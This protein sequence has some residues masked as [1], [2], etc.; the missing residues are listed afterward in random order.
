MLTADGVV[1]ILDFGLA[2]L[3]GAAGLT[4]AG[5]CLGTPAYMSPE[6]ARGEVDP[7][8]DL[9]SLGVV[10][11]EMLTGAPPFPGDI[12]P[13]GDLRAA[14]RRA[15][16]GRRKLRP[17]VPPE[18]ERI[19]HGML[20]KDPATA[21]DRRRAPWPTCAPSRLDRRFHGAIAAGAVRASRSG[22]PGCSPPPACVARRRGGRHAW[23]LPAVREP[24][25]QLSF[26]RLTDLEGREMFPS[27]SPAGDV[28][29]YAKVQAASDLDIFWQ[30]VGGGNPRI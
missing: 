15:G 16:G 25:P 6:Q 7:R 10:L 24:P 19:V 22:A 23:L 5:F 30:R 18:L 28:F 26:T 12:G 14:Q 3:A 4:R 2:K 21:T 1:K 8:T 20:A 27:L 17:E 11:Y 29:V 13:G 9:W